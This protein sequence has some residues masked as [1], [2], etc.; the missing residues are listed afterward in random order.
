MAFIRRT[1]GSI[2]FTSRWDFV[3][4]MALIT[5]LNI[6]VC[7][8]FFYKLSII[9][10]IPKHPYFFRRHSNSHLPENLPVSDRITSQIHQF[11]IC[12]KGEKHL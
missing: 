2:F 6:S 5:A 11:F 4:K 1:S 10:P 3:P 9:I 12:A 8:S 7:Q